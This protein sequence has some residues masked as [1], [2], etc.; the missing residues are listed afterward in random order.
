VSLS[1]RLA[2]ESDRITTDVIMVNLF[3]YLAVRYQA[4][5]IPTTVVNGR[6]AVVGAVADVEYIGRILAA[7]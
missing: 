2:V 6:T 1:T 3:P 5:D 4:G 7:A